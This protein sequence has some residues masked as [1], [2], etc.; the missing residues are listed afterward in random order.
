[1]T[2]S[3]FIDW[4]WMYFLVWLAYSIIVLAVGSF[5]RGMVRLRQR[6][7]AKDLLNRG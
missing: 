5:I 3:D 2:W 1:M 6:R 4:W 7:K